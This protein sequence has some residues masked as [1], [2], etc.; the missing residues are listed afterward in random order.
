[1]AFRYAAAASRALPACSS[2][3]ADMYDWS[4]AAAV[5][6]GRARRA[7][8][9]SPA[10]NAAGRRH[11]PRPCLTTFT[12][13]PPEVLDDRPALLAGEPAELIPRRLA[14]A[15]RGTARGV[16]GEGFEPLRPR[17]RSSFAT[18]TLILVIIIVGA[19]GIE[20]PREELL[21]ACERA[22]VDPPTV[23]RLGELPGL[24]RELTELAAL[25]AVAQV[26]E[27]LRDRALLPGECPAHRARLLA[28]LLPGGKLHQAL[29]P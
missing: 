27:T 29:R 14:E 17:R 11:R 5:V 7:S 15:R 16:S 1:M 2:S 13:D 12:V 3:I 6:A 22:R 23:E 9:S 25:V 4:W 21:L 19:A 28:R 18:R 20:Q 10:A 8:A 24:A 26:I